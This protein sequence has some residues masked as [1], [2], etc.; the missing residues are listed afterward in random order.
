[1]REYGTVMTKANQNFLKTLLNIVQ[2]LAATIAIL[3]G[4]SGLFSSTAFPEYFFLVSNLSFFNTSFAGR[5]HG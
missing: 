2:F 3:E 1:V 5:S 4:V